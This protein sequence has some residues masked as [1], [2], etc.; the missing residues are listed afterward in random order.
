MFSRIV[1]SSSASRFRLAI[2]FA[3]SEFSVGSSSGELSSDVP[4]TS[5]NR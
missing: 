1:F 2:S 5:A 4:K 3:F